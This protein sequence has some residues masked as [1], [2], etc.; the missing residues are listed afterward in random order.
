M[1]KHTLRVIT[2][3]IADGI[4]ADVKLFYNQH[5]NLFHKKSFEDWVYGV[6]EAYFADNDLTQE[7][8]QKKGRSY[9]IT[10]NRVRKNLW[11]AD[12]VRGIEADKK[13][14]DKWYSDAPDHYSEFYKYPYF[15]VL[16]DLKKAKYLGYDILDF[17]WATMRKYQYN[18]ER[19]YSLFPEE[20]VGLA[21]FGASTAT[22]GERTSI[23][24]LEGKDITIYDQ[25][26]KDNATYYCMRDKVA[27]GLGPQHA[28]IY[29]HL[30]KK[31]L[32]N[33]LFSSD[34]TE[35]KNVVICTTDE[36]IEVIG[37][38]EKRY[39]MNRQNRMVL[40]L[41]KDIALTSYVKVNTDTT[42]SENFITG[43]IR[44]ILEFDSKPLA[45]GSGGL[46]FTIEFP[47][48]QFVQEVTN[49]SL[50][51]T[52][53]VDVAAL[54]NKSHILIP[55]FQKQRM[56]LYDKGRKYASYPILSFCK[57]IRIP[58]KSKKS[59]LN[60]ITPILDDFKSKQIFI[61]NYEALDMDDQIMIEY[62]PLTETER[63]NILLRIGS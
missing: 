48:N 26:S 10:C 61:S 58:R 9:T 45:D 3:K 19:F 42:N 21:L 6:I 54:D 63:R 56:E 15:E 53:N 47:R 36:L 50:L 12:K 7:A 28:D 11:Q 1:D 16:T 35:D 38:K 59:I 44:L 29:K 24:T 25:F 52:C 20:M 37:A 18:I 13:L 5:D 8:L 14:L 34:D 31:Y 4:S 49:L 32:N 43:V 51:M 41:L 17:F 2:D 40:Q 55:F 62:F 23:I 27:N 33:M 22:K 46:V 60:I 39:S 30:F 57:V